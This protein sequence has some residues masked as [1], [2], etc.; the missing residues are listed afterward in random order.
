MFLRERE[1]FRPKLKF[2]SK[3]S[4]I[5][6][7]LRHSDINALLQNVCIYCVGT[8]QRSMPI[9][10][11]TKFFFGLFG[12]PFRWITSSLSWYRCNIDFSIRFR[13]N[14]KCFSVVDVCE[15][16]IW[17][18][19]LNYISSNLLLLWLQIFDAIWCNKLFT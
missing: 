5:Y 14:I 10:R 1:I 3:K 15:H 4:S 7:V 13:F 16:F 8:G 12:V 17:D 18:C 11:F 19:C 6:R 9:N 2:L